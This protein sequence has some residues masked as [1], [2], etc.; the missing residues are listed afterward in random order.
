ME[1]GGAAQDEVHGRVPPHDIEAEKAVLSAILLDN[2]AIHSVVTEVRE[3]DF[4]HPSHQILYHS[5]VRL[6][7]DNEPVDLTT[8]A[9]YLK[10]EGLLTRDAR[11]VERKKYGLR[12]ARRAPQF[13]KR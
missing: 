10:S 2:D 1:R 8:L 5:M 11:K 12:K 4:Y 7:D 13:T 6:R 3:A 9:A